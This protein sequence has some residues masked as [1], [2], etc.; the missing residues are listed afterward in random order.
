M[1]LFFLKDYVPVFVYMFAFS[2]IF[3]PFTLFLMQNLHDSLANEILYSQYVT[4]RGGSGDTLRPSASS[5]FNTKST[6]LYL[7]LCD[8]LPQTWQCPHAVSSTKD[9]NKSKWIMI[10]NTKQRTII[11]INNHLAVLVSFA[12]LYPPLAIL[13]FISI[14]I[15]TYFEERNTARLLRHALLYQKKWLIRRI[16]RECR[17]VANSFRYTTVWMMFLGSWLFAF[18]VF[19]MLG[20]KKGWK[21]AVGPAITMLFIPILLI[22][23]RFIK[24]YVFS[25]SSATKTSTSNSAAPITNESNSQ[26]QASPRSSHSTTQEE[27]VSSIVELQSFVEASP[28]ELE[29][30]FSDHMRI[31]SN[32]PMHQPSTRP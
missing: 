32:N 15:L 22:V 6:Y 19:D 21:V 7:L 18:F 16:N 17:G 28:P 11:R 3:V 14:C 25:L 1:Q 29:S 24:I 4:L 13:A 5:T 12:A 10:V 30:V 27:N 20:D 31:S 2:S 8:W 9:E 26:M 23:A